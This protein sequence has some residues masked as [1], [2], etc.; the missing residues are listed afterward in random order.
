MERAYSLNRSNPDVVHSMLNLYTE[1]DQSSDV[2]IDL[3]EKFVKD[4]LIKSKTKF[5][6]ERLAHLYVLDNQLDNAASIY[7]NIVK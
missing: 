5:A 4:K 2:T 1:S 6:F 7:Q 3:L